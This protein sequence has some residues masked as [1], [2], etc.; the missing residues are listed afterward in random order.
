MDFDGCEEFS[1][2]AGSA[3]KK[4]LAQAWPNSVPA[5][6]VDSV[7]YKSEWSRD[8][9]STW[10]R[11]K[12]K[13]PEA[14]AW[15]D[16]VHASEEESAEVCA[17]MHDGT[18]YAPEGVNRTVAGPPP[19]HD[20][21]GTTPAWWSPPSKEFRATEVMVWY[22]EG[23]SGTDSGTGRA[24]YSAFDDSDN[25]LWIYEYTAQHDLLWSRG[26]VPDGQRLEFAESRASN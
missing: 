2:L 6:A 3:A 11:I 9:S 16:Y 14:A 18:Y 22:V 8:S 4:E 13:Q 7:D 24:T 17:T 19:L 12:L 26:A 25:T 20:Q 1:G 10:Y 23:D 15:M 5:D 21:T